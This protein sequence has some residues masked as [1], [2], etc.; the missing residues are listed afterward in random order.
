VKIAEL[1]KRLEALEAE[2]R[3]LREKLALAEARIAELEQIGTRQ[4]APFRREPRRLV[5]PEQKKKPGRKPGH[6]GFFRQAPPRIDEEVDVPLERCPKCGGALSSV[7]ELEQIIE[8]IEPVRPKVYRLRTRRGVCACGCGEVRSSHPLQRALQRALQQSLAGGCAK[9]QL[10][11][12]AV[13]L[14]VVLN[15]SLGMT[16]RKTLQVLKLTSGLR[17]TPGGLAQITQITQRAADRLKGNY[18]ALISQLRAA[19]VVHADE[20]SWH[21]GEHLGKQPDGTV[22]SGTGQWLWTF[23]TPKATLYTVDKRASETV[24]RILGANFKGVLV[25]DC[26]ASYDAIDCRKHKCIAH[27]LRA[28]KSAL[29]L[30]PHSKYLK[31]WQAFFKSVTQLWNRR[32]RGIARKRVGRKAFAREHRQLLLERDQLLAKAPVDAAEKKIRNR[33]IKHRPHLLRCLDDPDVEPT[34]NRAERALRPAVIARKLSCGNKTDRGKQAFQILTSLAVTANQRGQDFVEL[35][36]KK[37]PLTAY[38]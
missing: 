24:G 32:A 10:G 15:K 16:V 2:N 13:A 38:G 6:E 25:S 34:N 4:A 21:V 7:T 33:M 11:P 35:L 37:L 18:D 29:A 26:L 27:H 19:A 1:V 5:E 31:R 30:S 28:I 12:R 17:L 20:T 3:L 22:K 14:A 23:T 36:R 9:V 8:E